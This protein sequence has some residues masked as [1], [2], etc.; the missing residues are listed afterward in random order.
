MTDKKR[1]LVC[2]LDWG[3]GH[4]SRDSIIIQKLSARGHEIIIAGSGLSLSLLK[5]EFPY[6]KFISLPASEIKYDRKIPAWLAILKLLPGWIINTIREHRALIKIIRNEQIDL[7]ISDARYGLWN[8]GIPSVLITHQLAIKLPVKSKFFERMIIS[9]NRLVIRRFNAF[10]IPDYQGFPNLSGGLSHIPVIPKNARFIGPLSRFDGMEQE[11]PKELKYEVVA[12]ISGP[13]PQRSVFEE[14]LT[15]QLAGFGKK[16]LMVCGR[17][18]KEENVDITDYC[19]RVS[20]L[21]GQELSDVLISARFIICRSGYS[22]IMDLAALK[23]TA[24]LVPTPGQTEQEYLADYLS[25]NN[26]F[27]YYKQ[28]DFNLQDALPVLENYKP[29]NLE[30]DPSLLANAISEL[31]KMGKTGRPTSQQE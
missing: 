5:N 27:P 11:A 30:F 3:L 13:E 26:M 18:D 24:C 20:F 31:E 22:S 6:K 8:S 1:I 16:S 28:K 9:I 7:V 21:T 4:A 25:Q 14:L 23:K 2:P 29:A 17:P 19:T 12:V 15:I 10:W